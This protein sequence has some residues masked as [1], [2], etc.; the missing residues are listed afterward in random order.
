M[1]LPIL[2]IAFYLLTLADGP[3]VAQNNSDKNE[4]VITGAM[5]A[6]HVASA[7]SGFAA[8]DAGMLQ[9][10]QY[11]FQELLGNVARFG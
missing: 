10:K 9:V 1:K 7:F 11:G 4:V 5:H 3:A 2:F 6:Q 8:K